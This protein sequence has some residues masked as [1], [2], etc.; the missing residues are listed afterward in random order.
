MEE[1]LQQQSGGKRKMPRGPMLTVIIVLIVALLEGGAFFIAIKWFGAGVQPTYGQGVHVLEDQEVATVETAE[2]TLLQ[3]FRV[4]N[5]KDG[6]LKI[7]DLDVTVVVPADD[8]ARLKRIEEDLKSRMGEVS[9]RSARVIR[10]ASPRTMNEDDLR[11]LRLQLKTEFAEI[12][13][14]P[15]AIMRVLI[16]RCVPMYAG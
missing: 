10:A 14:D 3:G 5:N 6:Q 16:P 12:L 2:V 4:P 15:D 11:T 7:F 1:E 9:D 8:E 13:G